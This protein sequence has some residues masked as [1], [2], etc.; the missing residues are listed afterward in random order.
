MY[1]SDRNRLRVIFKYCFNDIRKQ[2][3]K[4]KSKYLCRLL[5]QTIK[6]CFGKAIV[7]SSAL[8][9]II[10]LKSFNPRS[11]SPTQALGNRK[12]S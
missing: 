12:S 3:K 1:K 9:L 7:C 8:K 2:K 10:F 4:I 5:T 11:T 6:C